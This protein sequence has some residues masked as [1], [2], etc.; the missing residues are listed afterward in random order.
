MAGM[1][2][3]TQAG[4]ATGVNVFLAYADSVHAFGDF[5]NPWDGSPN[6]T[7]DGCRGCSF[8][9]GAIRI[10][11]D[12][13]SSVAV[14]QINVHI[15][16]CLYTWNGALYPVT[17]APRASL[18]ATQRVAGASGCTGPDPSSFDSSDI[19]ST[20]ICVNDGI[21]PTVDV[22]VN[23]ITTS[24]TDLGQVLNSG[25]IDPATCTGSNEST[26]WVKIGS[27]ACPG[28]SLSLSPATQTDPVGSTASVTATLT[29]ACGGALSG[30]LTTFK[31]VAGANAGMTGAGSTDPNGQVS[32]SYSSLLPGTDAL[33]A[34]VTN[35]VGFTQTSN[36]VTVV[37]TLE[38]GPGGGS[39]VIGNQNAVSGSTVYFW[40]SQW[41]KQN[42]LSGGPAPRSFKGFAE[43]PTAPDCG[44]SWTADPGNSTPPPDG[45]LPAFMGVIVTSSADQSGSTI[46]GDTVAIVVVKTGSGYA[47]NP[48]HRATGTVVAVVC[49]S[50]AAGASARAGSQTGTAGTGSGASTNPPPVAAG[51]GCPPKPH[52][53]PGHKEPDCSPRARS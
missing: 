11:N 36:T 23:G 4:A 8:D 28:Q 53:R 49:G 39:F 47:P 44:K 50:S 38:F 41:A 48:G 37:W 17:L 16:A 21:V 2:P 14:D 1:L 46:G 20:G 51:E 45:P 18:I 32:F 24:G 26:Q 13:T 10:E 9:A 12:N 35:A 3:A 19:P 42:S 6:V 31:V 7:F 5:P 34:T 52:G 22:T 43:E 29:N 25:G 30:V 15:G 33:H 40:G 27:R